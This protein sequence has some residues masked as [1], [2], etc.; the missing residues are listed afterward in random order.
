MWPA[1]KELPEIYSIWAASEMGQ[2][3]REASMGERKQ[4]CGGW[5]EGVEVWVFGNREVCVC[6]G[7]SR[8]LESVCVAKRFRVK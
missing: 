4:Q 6:W 1:W 2:L 3:E 7:V 5:G 8:E